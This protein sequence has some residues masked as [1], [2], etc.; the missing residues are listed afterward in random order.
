[1]RTITKEELVRRLGDGRTLVVNVLAKEGYDRI[2]IRGSISM[3]RGEMQLGGWDKLDRSKDI[4]VHC[5]S[6][7]C[8]ASKMAGELLEAKGFNVLE[9]AGGMREWAEAGLPTEGRVTAKEYLAE[10]YPTVKS[11]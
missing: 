1:M 9:Y 8:G 6:Y 4:V 5:S 2:H 3:P 11:A 7:T 10:H